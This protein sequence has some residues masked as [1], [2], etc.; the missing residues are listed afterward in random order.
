MGR[1]PDYLNVTF[2]GF[3]GR[4]DEW[5]TKGNERGAANL[6]AYQ[7]EMARRDLSLTHT[8]IHPTIDKARGDVPKPGDEVALHKVEDTA[9]GI[10]VR[11][12]RI[13]ATLAPFSDELAV[14]PAWPLPPGSDAYALAFSIPMATPGLKFLCRD[15]CSTSGNLFDHPLSSRFDEQ[16]A[17]VIFDDVEVPRDRVFIDANLEAYNSVMMTGWAP[18][19]M[20]QTMIRAQTKLEFAWGLASRMVEVIN[21]GAPATFEM[22][23]ELWS[24]AEF[25]RASVRA[26]EAGARE[27]GNGVWFPDVGPLT[28]LRAALPTWFPARERDHPPARLAQPAGRA[29]LV[30]ARRSELAA[31]HRPLPARRQGRVGRGSHPRVPARLGLRRQRAREPQRAVR[32]LLP[33]VGRPQLS[34]GAHHG[35]DSSGP[36]SWS[37]ASS[38]R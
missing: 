10:L 18:N 20:Q 24:Y 23:G 1:T 25:A 12:A 11:G 15:S 37:T 21:A 7:K 3:A 16:D 19:I 30:P 8:I 36:A 14:Y 38:R 13:L 31:A 29:H 4:A 5:A 6:V 22:L 33:G 9:R 28:A 27:Q 17:F 34:D 32:A 26:A 2:A 35:A